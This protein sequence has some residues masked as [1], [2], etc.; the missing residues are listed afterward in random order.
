MPVDPQ[1]NGLLQMIEA[2]GAPALADGTPAQAREGFRLM[3]VGMR[4]PATLAS[5][6]SVEDTTVPGPTGPV[7]VRLYRPDAEGALPTIVF[8]HDGGFVIGDLDTHDDHARLLCHEVGAVVVSVD[9]RLA[10]EHPFPAGFLDCLAA[11]HHIS[12]HTGLYGGNA[13][14]LAVAGDS[15]GANLAAAVALAARD[16]GLALAAQ[17]L[18]YPGVD[19]D[20][21]APHVSRLENAT[22]FF[23]TDADMRWF[24]EQYLSDAAH[25]SDPRASVLLADLS[26]VAPAIIGTAEFD[27]LR[28]EGEA[29][30]AALSKAGVSVV[31]RRYD[32]MIHGFFGLGH[33]SEAAKAANAELCADLTSLLA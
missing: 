26:G 21:D 3:T 19:F 13:R 17:L 27:P 12:E 1:I 25:R 28:D 30:A 14:R 10:P 32:G 8:F 22:G 11:L 9:Y 24:G 6:R 5:V 31:A 33:L 29:Y 4:D 18:L 16:E 15:A 2:A 20:E 7:P 23:L